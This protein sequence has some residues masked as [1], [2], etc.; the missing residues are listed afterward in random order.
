M[1]LQNFAYRYDIDYFRN[2]LLLLI[3]YYQDL[4]QACNPQ[5]RQISRQHLLIRIRDA[6]ACAAVRQLAVTTVRIE[7]TNSVH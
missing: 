2:L 7:V 4:Q 1:S 6:P 3:S 5:H